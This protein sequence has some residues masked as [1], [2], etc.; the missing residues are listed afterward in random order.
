MRAANVPLSPVA[1]HPSRSTRRGIRYVVRQRLATPGRRV[2]RRTHAVRPAKSAV[3]NNGSG[4]PSAPT[5][6][7]IF[8]EKNIYSGPFLHSS[9]YD[10]DVTIRRHTIRVHGKNGSENENVKANACGHYRSGRN[11]KPLF[12][13]LKVMPK[14]MCSDE[15]RGLE[16]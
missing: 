5:T 15:R 14:K 12:A 13:I 10:D 2:R 4:V 9:T 7:G 8:D 6:G 1:H 11:E 3:S 16:N